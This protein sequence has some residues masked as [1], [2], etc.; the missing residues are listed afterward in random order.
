V[1]ALTDA[2]SQT[3]APL[4]EDAISRQPVPVS[5]ELFLEVSV[6][7]EASGLILRF[8]RGAAGLRS[9]VQNLRDLDL[10][11]ALF[12]LERQ[13]EFDL[14]SVKGLSYTYD[15]G[16]QRLALRVSD[17]LRTP[18]SLS[19]RDV[20]RPAPA[21]VTPGAVANYDLYTQLGSAHSASLQSEL[22]YFSGRGVWINNG[23]W[24]VG[25]GQHQY[26]RFDTYWS[27]SDPDTL[28]TWQAGDLISSSLS[29]SRSLRMGGVQWRRS[30]DLRPDLLTYPVATLNGAAVVPSAVSVYIN[31]VRQ[32]EMAVPAGPFVVNQVAGIN[33]A[34]QATLVTRDAAGRAISTTL[35]LY[36]DT[37]MLAAGLS[38]YSVELGALRRNYGRDSFAYARTPAASAA[39][40]YGVSERL[41]L[42]AHGEAGRG[43]LN[44]GGAALWALGRAGVLSASLAGSTG[45]RTDVQGVL[46][47]PDDRGN[48]SIGTV[49]S[50]SGRGGQAS[51]GYQ[52]LSRGFSIDAQRFRASNGYSDLGT[53]SGSL[54]PLASDRLTLN[55]TLPR[56][57]SLGASYVA[58]RAPLSAN[59]RIVAAS[60]SA[61]LGLGL[62]LSAS[63][64]RD[65]NDPKTR[66]MFFSLSMSF[67]DRIAVNASRSRQSGVPTR[68]LAVARAADYGGG[69][70]WSL[71]QTDSGNAP[72]RQA[73]LQYLSGHGQL[74]VFAQDNDGQ[75]RGALD[76]AGALVLMDGSL[77]ATRQVGAGFALV[78]TDGV[79]GVPVLQGNRAIG[80]T[81]RGGYLLVPNLSPYLSNPLAIDTSALPLD[82]RIA[83]TA[84]AVVPARLSGVLARFP[85]EKYAAASVVLHTPDGKP[86][87]SGTTVLHVESGRRSVVGFD[88]LAFVEYLQADNHLLLGEGEARC[89][90]QF[91]Y[92]E[93]ALPALPTLGPLVCKAMH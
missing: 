86:V 49:Y 13:T 87:A 46:G 47:P 76:L 19:A 88:G 50:A 59:A 33:G 89:T 30:F 10:D 68:T 79:A 83:T 75:R 25:Q 82:A 71:F 5:N 51:L 1:W 3:T 18:V 54:T 9:T 70:G 29:W 34:S 20:S 91:S 24:Y 36:V 90:V 12:G 61:P 69:L 80:K 22:R 2:R 27:Y 57:Q 64:F 23:A 39:L 92:A 65:I 6:N 84:L 17:A 37:R 67:G 48:V 81:D 21:V 85:V 14:D 78:S 45:R 40:R 38:D 55:L 63:A 53:A 8:T 26:V 44:G 52:Y 93:E 32:A 31:G 15:A 43:L 56:G 62:Y 28:E 42:E 72:L 11:P 60:Y 74:S 4:S 73:H 58:M 35:P 66:G 7:G 16:L 77:Q 41:T